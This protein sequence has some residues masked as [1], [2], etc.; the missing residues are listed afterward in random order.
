[1]VAQLLQNTLSQ[2]GVYEILVTAL[3]ICIIIEG[4][5]L[6]IILF[7]EKKKKGGTD[8]E[9]IDY[10]FAGPNLNNF[11][12]IKNWFANKRKKDN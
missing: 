6:P 1:M 3:I 7:K 2:G 4:I 8:R 9:A 11:R 10:A 12:A 5:A